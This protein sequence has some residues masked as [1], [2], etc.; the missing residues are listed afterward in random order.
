MV[1]AVTAQWHGHNYQA[2][3]FWENALNL[4]IPI[5]VSSR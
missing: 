5:L 2:R 1:S 4:L 3:I